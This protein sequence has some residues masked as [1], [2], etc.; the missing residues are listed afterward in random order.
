MLALAKIRLASF[1]LA[2]LVLILWSLDKV[3]AQTP[4]GIPYAAT[5][6]NIAPPIVPTPIVPTP[7]TPIPVVPSPNLVPTNAPPSP[8]YIYPSYGIINVP[9]LEVPPTV[10]VMRWR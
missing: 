3:F 6:A 7:N 5:P 1:S 8:V 10:R 2:L 4:Y 9:G